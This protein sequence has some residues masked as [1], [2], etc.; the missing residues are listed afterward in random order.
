MKPEKKINLDLCFPAGFHTGS[1]Y[2]E[3][4]IALIMKKKKKKK[5]KYTQ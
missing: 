1:R 3:T 2:C 5:L 4:N